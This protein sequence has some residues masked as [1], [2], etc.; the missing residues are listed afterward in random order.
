MA[1][2][3]VRRGVWTLAADAAGDWMG[4]FPMRLGRY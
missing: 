2:K 1:G 4:T 3:K